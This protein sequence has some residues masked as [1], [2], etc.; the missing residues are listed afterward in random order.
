[1]TKKQIALVV[2]AIIAGG[3]LY[4]A[5]TMN[6]K[7][8]MHGDMDS[9]S[10]A[11]MHQMHHGGGQ[12]EHD[13]VNMP[14]LIGLNASKRESDELAKMFREFDKLSRTVTNLDNGIRTVT[15]ASDPELMQ[16]LIS[17]V[18]G[19]IARVHQGDDPK[20]AIQSPTLDVFF[21]RGDQILTDVKI[22]DEG[23]VVVQTSE[24]PELVK[25]LQVHAEEVTAMVDRGMAAVHEMMMARM[26]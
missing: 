23:I 16:V 10:Y 6:G 24:D 25:A 13:E 14:G 21:M 26:K 17:H 11:K 9:E 3:A 15:N 12:M 18:T 2:G 5:G 22:T 4:A 7:H 8:G 20:I 19:M 1:M